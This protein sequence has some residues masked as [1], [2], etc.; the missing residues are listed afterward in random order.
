MKLLPRLYLR[1]YLPIIFIFKILEYFNLLGDDNFLSVIPLAG[2][3]LGLTGFNIGRR[4]FSRG[5]SSSSS[6]NAARSLSRIGRQGIPSDLISSLMQNQERQ[7]GASVGRQQSNVAQ[8]LA[9]TGISSGS[10]LAQELFGNIA[11]QGLG[12]RLAANQNIQLAS[13]DRQMQALGLLLNRQQNPG[14]LQQTL[15]VAA[16]ALPLLAL[17]G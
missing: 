7:I 15:G 17:R 2:I 3:G 11:S 6:D 13:L 5:G 16:Q 4:L 12:Q 8:R 9:S 10:G 14:L 1:K